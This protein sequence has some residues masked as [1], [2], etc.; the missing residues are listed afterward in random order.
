MDRT[1]FKT[2]IQ[3][4]NDNFRRNLIAEYEK[5][6]MSVFFAPHLAAYHE[7]KPDFFYAVVKETIELPREIFTED[8]D[9]HLEHDFAFYYVD[10]EKC[11]FKI[12]YYDKD[13]KG[14]CGEANILNDDIC[15]R[16]ITVGLVNGDW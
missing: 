12:D 8:N 10:D 1:E 6:K 9:P 15:R 3:Q 16:V 2:L 5:N 7:T 13:Y 4:K 11:F 14:H